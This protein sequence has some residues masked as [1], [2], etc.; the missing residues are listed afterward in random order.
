MLLPESQTPDH[1][2]AVHPQDVK[3]KSA[4]MH[5]NTKTDER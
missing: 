4:Q 2:A 3:T 1:T 5:R